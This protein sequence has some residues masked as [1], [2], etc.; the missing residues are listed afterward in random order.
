MLRK[1]S[2]TYFFVTLISIN[3]KVVVFV[4]SSSN[5]GKR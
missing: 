3:K 4:T 2:G 1:D 5:T